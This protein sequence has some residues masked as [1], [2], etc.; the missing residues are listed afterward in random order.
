MTAAHTDLEQRDP[1]PAAGSLLSYVP[2]LLRTWPESTSHLDVD[3]TLLSADL[4]GFTRLSE[5][6]AALGRE[7]AEELT[8]LL[9]GVFTRM[10][11]EIERFGG[12]VLKF[13]GDALLVLY[14]GAQHTERA[15]YSTIAMRDL[16]AEPLT[17]STGTRVRLRISQGMHAGTFSCFVLDGNHR[18]LMVTGPGVT[19]TVECEGTAIAGQILLSAAAAAAV[20]PKWL[21][22]AVDDRRLL[23]RIVVLDEPVTL[24]GDGSP[25]IDVTPFVPEAQR[26]QIEIGAPSEHRRVAIGFVKF[27]HADELIEREGASALEKRLQLLAQAVARAERDFGVHWL[28]SDVY[29]DGGKVILTAGAPLTLGDDEERV[30]RAARQILD[31][32]EGLDLRIGVNAGPVFVGDLGSPSRR[33]FTVMGDAVNL[34]ARLMQKA[35]SGQLIASDATLDRSPTRFETTEL[36]AFFVKGK[37]VP[38]RASI[39]GAV[40]AKREQI[41]RLTLIGRDAELQVLLDAATSAKDGAGQ[42]VE[43]VGEPGAGKSRL[44]EELRRREPELQLFTAQ[45]G[46]YART[47]PYFAVRTML[48]TIAGIEPDASAGEAAQ[49]LGDFV[50]TVMPQATPLLP[51]LAIPFDVDLPPTPAVLRIAEQFRR[52]RSHETATD[53]IAAAL[54]APT[55]LLVEDLHW[56]DDASRD[57]VGDL[58]K[59]VAGQPWLVV[60]TSRPGSEP[61]D[62]ADAAKIALHPLDEDAALELVLAAAGTDSELRPTDWKRLVERAGG[63]PLFA[64][65]L[66]EAARSQGTVDVLADSVESLVTSKIDTLPAR[67]R[68]LL[69]ESAVLG[70]VVDI[71]LLADALED[72]DIRSPA[73]WRPLDDF[74][75]WDGD[76]L[77]FRHA[78]HQH[79]AYEGLS[80]RRR[81]EMHAR[82][83]QAIRGRF[84]DHP[85]AVAGLLST[86]YSRA[87]HHDAAWEF[88]VLAGNDARA[89]Y[90]NVEAGEF[91]ARALDAA[92]SLST[93]D[94]R[95]VASVAESLG[96]VRTLTSHYDGAR[97]AYGTARR[98][99][100]PPSPKEAE[101]LRKIGRV[102]EF[103]GRYSQAVRY[104]SRALKALDALGIDTSSNRAAVFAAFG[105]ARYRQGKIDEARDWAF[106]AIAEAERTEDLPAL[107]HAYRLLEICLE[108]RGDPQ[109]LEYRGRALPLYE[110]LDDQVGLGEELINLA[111]FLAVDGQLS[112]ALPVIERAVRVKRRVGDVVG[113]AGCINNLGELLLQQGRAAEALPHLEQASRIV[114][115]TSHKM[116]IMI[117]R[118]SL[119]QALISTGERERGFALIDEAIAL[120]NEI[121]AE[122]RANEFRARKLQSLVEVGRN[123]EAFE[124]AEF[125]TP[126]ANNQQV[127]QQLTITIPRLYAWLHLRRGETDAADEKLRT[128]LDRLGSLESDELAYAL[129]ARAEVRRRRGDAPGAQDDDAH[130]RQ[131]FESLGILHVPRLLLEE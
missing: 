85:D 37:T 102:L 9:N 108:E 19:E 103:E 106:K 12:D 45:C 4:S 1:A 84:K 66:A 5:R 52:G 69:R 13:G 88:S 77:R 11:A 44:L 83:A 15:C 53:V 81:R 22:R 59:R 36:E 80:Y 111:N 104:Y 70:A 60:L 68:V 29:P 38:I 20:D 71:G 123:R 127:E 118:S 110:E 39:V 30:L 49:T 58:L 97:V 115:T 96:D 6:L 23:R 101:L 65:E 128:A 57:L 61:L 94:S 76:A 95:D 27:S 54:S 26:E 112:E 119:G 107:A 34:A 41:G 74:M 116:L 78:I 90:A 130:A 32:I 129:L 62:V 117:V 35:E 86:H 10:I 113:E 50:D 73:R 122:F 51:L 43:I 28:A 105:A 56:I 79:V 131:I 64:I 16:I 46:Q 89:K 63:N 100:S 109:R 87:G 99:L 14:Q 21:G 31:E 18:E 93:L 17:T 55:L 125:L 33:A 3:G 2:R 91:Y 8:V 72:D 124:L 47:S 42:V 40:Q 126:I 25:D 121:G 98:N 82:A 48:R 114:E 92:R 67:D 120:A 75:L 7:G 24:D